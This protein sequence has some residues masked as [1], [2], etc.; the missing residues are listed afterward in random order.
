ME[1]GDT[2]VSNQNYQEMAIVP[3]PGNEKQFYLFSGGVTLTTNPGFYW[4]LVDLTYNGGLGRVVQKNVQLQNFP[5][6][7]GL[8]AVKHGNGRDWWVI[9]KQYVPGG[10]SDEVYVYLV[11]PSGISQMPVKH[12]GRLSQTNTLRLKFSPSG[13]KLISTDSNQYLEL[14]DFDRCTGLLSNPR[15]VHQRQ[16]TTL[17]GLF[18]SS[19][20]SPDETKL[21]LS[22][23]EYGNN[24]SISCLIQFDLLA[25]DIQ[26][27]MD[28]IYNFYL[29][30]ET[31]MLKLGPDN[32]IYLSQYLDNND[33][34]FFYLYCDTTFYP[35]NMNISVIHQPNE[36]GALCDF[37]PYSFYL[38]GHRS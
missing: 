20:F 3:N 21:Y 35:E 22:T 29:P 18:W 24:D 7:D 37:R 15:F 34:G 23:V 4:S 12:I 31:G 30:Y 27:S 17:N 32:K 33:C 2:I 14:F 8:A 13:T 6:N 10:Y 5:V 28:T 11:D 16:V 25:P 38:G 9:H 19:E 26:A 36:L 1:D